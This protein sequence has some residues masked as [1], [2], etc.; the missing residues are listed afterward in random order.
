MK[1][2]LIVFVRGV[3]IVNQVQQGRPVKRGELGFDIGPGGLRF[4]LLFRHGILDG[5]HAIGPIQRQ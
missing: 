3:Q 1:K 2:R 4:R 5:L